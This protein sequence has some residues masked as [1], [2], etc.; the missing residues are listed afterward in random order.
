MSGP[1][2]SGGQQPP[3]GQPYGQPGASGTTPTTPGWGGGESAPFGGVAPQSQYPTV[4]GNFA[5]PAPPAPKRRSLR[6]L[7]I[8]LTVVVVVLVVGGGAGAFALT[9]YAAPAAE[10]LVFCD[11]LKAHNY[12]AAY[13]DLSTSMQAQ[14]TGDEFAKGAQFIEVTEG[15]ITRCVQSAGNGAYTYSFGAKKATL[16]ATMTRSISGTLAGNIGLVQEGGAW[17]VG[18]IDTSLLGINLGALKTAGAFCAALQTQNYSAAYALL[19]STEQQKAPSDAFAAVLALNDAIDG[20]ITTCTLE[21]FTVSGSDSNASL[22]VAF[23]RAT[24]GALHG[25]VKL[26]VEGG[27]WKI[28]DVA[29]SLGGTDVGPIL[30]GQQFCAD[31]VANKLTD[32]FALLSSGYAAFEGSQDHFNS[33]WGVSPPFVWDSCTPDLKTYKVTGDTATVVETLTAKDTSTGDTGS[34]KYTF[35]YFK[36]NGKWGFDGVSKAP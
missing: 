26:K 31:L 6:W 2:D 13:N 14:V 15:N 35:H 11:H 17:K 8:T 16:N 27:G 36:E 34:S 3:F 30:V 4:P 33:I 32:A 28:D 18:S 24:L 12:A 7:W 23:A 5:P 21:G 25:A 9:Q 22:N 29:D 10:G 20:K 1:F 19:S